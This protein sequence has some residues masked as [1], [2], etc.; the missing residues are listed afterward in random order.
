M[1][2]QNNNKLMIQIFPMTN[3]KAVNLLKIRR[4]IPV[5]KPKFS[6]RMS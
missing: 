2:K 6:D 1:T 5:G 4:I 3:E